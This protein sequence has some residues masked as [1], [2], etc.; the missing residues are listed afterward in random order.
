M[1]RPTA[2]ERSPGAPPKAALGPRAHPRDRARL[3]LSRGHSRR[4]RRYADCPL[5]RGQ[6]ELL[7]QLPLQGRAGL[8]LPRI[9][10]RRVLA[11]VGRSNR[12][13]R[14]RAAQTVARVVRRRP[15]ITPSRQNSADARSATRWSS[16]PRSAIRRARSS[17]S[18]GPSATPGCAS[19]QRPQAR[20]T[21]NGSRIELG[22][23]LEG[24]GF[25]AEGARPAGRASALVRA[26][27]TLID[28]E[29]RPSQTRARRRNRPT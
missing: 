5:G 24:S 16:S 1:Q 23:V 12:G 9:L 13:P 19:L 29:T 17:S 18:S 14:A 7:P 10:G 3:V 28:A 11:M 8:R 20:A 4:W 2:G 6:D 26:A 27:E 25:C 15:R 22:I 21:R